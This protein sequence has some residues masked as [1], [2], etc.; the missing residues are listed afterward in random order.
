MASSL[1]CA[2][3]FRVMKNV[4]SLDG[5][6]MFE[7]ENILQEC[8]DNNINISF[9]KIGK[10]ECD[11]WENYNYHEHDFERVD[12]GPVSNIVVDFDKLL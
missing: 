2:E 7:A 4:Y 6:K 11:T 9:A 12:E 5:E 3:V 10:E 1:K 8:A